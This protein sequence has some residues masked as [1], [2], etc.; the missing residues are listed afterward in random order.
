[1]R[2]AT[3]VN[4]TAVKAMDITVFRSHMAT[5]RYNASID[6]GGLDISGRIIT[7]VRSKMSKELKATAR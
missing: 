2:K 1:M 4:H 6:K 7:H 5:L 3:F